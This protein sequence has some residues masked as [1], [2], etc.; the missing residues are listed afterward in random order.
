MENPS[1][2]AENPMNQSRP[3]DRKMLFSVLTIGS[4]REL[5]KHR[6]FFVLIFIVLIA[7]KVL[8]SAFDFDSVKADISPAA[9][10]GR[11]PEFLF[12]DLPQLI[13]QWLFTPT[14]LAILCGL[15]LFKQ[16]VSLW[17]SSSL[18]RWHNDNSNAGMLRSLLGLNLPQFCWD[19]C[20]IGI[21]GS[22]V[23]IWSGLWYLPCY[24]WWR[25]SG[26]VFPAWILLAVVVVVWP[27]I[28]AGL[29]YSSKLAVLHNGSFKQK[30]ALFI[31]LFS[32]V[33]ILIGSWIFFLARIIVEVIFVA[34][35]PLGAL[36]YLENPVIRVA[37]ICLSI[38]PSYSYLK[39]ASFKFFVFIYRLEPLVQL[40][41]ADYLEKL[42]PASQSQ[43][44]R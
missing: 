44:D 38:T 18:R 24:L 5:V 30:F 3:S 2:A 25:A 37:L 31:K 22:L 33:R 16:V 7:D 41:F 32:N 23:L 19:F 35:I 15:F 9:I 20:A 4:V 43:G 12:V 39:M 42:S 29:S 1:K 26:S 10:I 6:S 28:M 21:L 14:A 27:L 40:E 36:L 8:H 11:L 13:E 34:V 17:P